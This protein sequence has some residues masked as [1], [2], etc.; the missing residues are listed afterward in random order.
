MGADHDELVLQ[1]LWLFIFIA[2][3]N[4][5]SALGHKRTR[6]VQKQTS[7]MANLRHYAIAL[8]G[9]DADKPLEHSFQ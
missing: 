7:A 2:L 9:L 8:V 1:D 6:A 4:V 3:V 5:M